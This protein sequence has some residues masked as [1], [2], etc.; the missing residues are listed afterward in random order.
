MQGTISWFLGCH[1]PVHSF[2]VLLSWR[3]LHGRWPVFWQV[4]CILLHDIG[5]IG[6]NYLDH[7]WQKQNHWKRGAY[8]CGA[9]FG[10]KGFLLVA[11]HD[12]HSGYR[13]SALYKPDK[14]AAYIAPVWWLVTNTFFEPKM[15]M[16]Y[17]RVEAVRRFKEQAKKN[18]ESGAYRS[19]HDLYL[20]R[21]RGAK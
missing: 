14:Y 9:L 19:N 7:A 5:H 8:I 3:K 13:Q 6:L 4:A 10:E 21:C 18:I 11:G 1:S 16:G 17:G 15:R 2:L 12:A 20:E